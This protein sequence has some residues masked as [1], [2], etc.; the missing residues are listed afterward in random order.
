VKL[1]LQGTSRERER[2]DLQTFCSL[3]SLLQ[4]EKGRKEEGTPLLLS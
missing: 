4:E 1:E 2:R 3:A